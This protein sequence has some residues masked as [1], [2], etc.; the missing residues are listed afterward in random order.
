MSITVTNILILI[1]VVI[2]YAAF[3]NMDIFL[4]YRHHPYTES[5]QKN[6]ISWLTSGFLHG[7][8]VHLAINMFV[9]WQFGNTVERIYVDEFG[10]TGSILFLVMY[11][12][13]IIFAN[14]PSFRKHKDNSQYAAVGASGAVAAVM[15]TYILFNPWGGIY[16]YG[17]I[18]IRIVVGGLLYLIYEQWASQNAQDN[19]GHDAHF[20][21]AIYG[22]LFIVLIRPSICND[23]V[24]R[25]IYQM[26]SLQKIFIF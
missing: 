6:Y 4:K 5:R 19:I 8:Y 24:D 14:L 26:P 23:F 9:L 22:M 16:L 2:S 15:F 1:T 3:N 12:S 21:G 25:L 17:I 11:L 20:A 18:P 10:S 13:A 7:D